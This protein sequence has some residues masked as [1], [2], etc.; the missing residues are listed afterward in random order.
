MITLTCGNRLKAKVEALVSLTQTHERWRV[1]PDLAF[2]LS[3]TKRG[4]MMRRPL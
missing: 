3:A 1:T 2:I 4:M